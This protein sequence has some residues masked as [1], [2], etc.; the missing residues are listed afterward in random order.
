MLEGSTAQYIEDCFLSAATWRDFC[1]SRHVA[2]GTRYL[3]Y[4]DLVLHVHVQVTRSSYFQ[5]PVLLYNYMYL[6]RELAK[7]SIHVVLKYM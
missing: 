5:V 7:F 4:Q 2:T 1:F 6:L 3:Y